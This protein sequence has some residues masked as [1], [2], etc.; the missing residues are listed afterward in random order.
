MRSRWKKVRRLEKGT[1]PPVVT[2]VTNMRCGFGD[3]HDDADGGDDDLE[4]G[5]EPYLILVTTATTGGSVPFSS[6][7]TFFHREGK[8]DCLRKVY[9]ETKNTNLHIFW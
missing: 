8:I 3:Y 2:V 6:R 1:L 9:S 4:F 7:R 5:T